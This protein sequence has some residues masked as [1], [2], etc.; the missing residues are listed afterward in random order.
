MQGSP[1]T[2]THGSGGSAAWNHVVQHPG[3]QL[4]TVTPSKNSKEDQ[5]QELAEIQFSAT[6]SGKKL[7][8]VLISTSCIW[9]QYM[10]EAL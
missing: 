9:A 3:P 10:L 7:Q 2:G 8:K 6:Q 4:S 1:C 5:K